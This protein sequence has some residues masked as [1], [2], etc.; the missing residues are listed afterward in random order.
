M[1]QEIDNLPSTTFF[2]RRFTRRRLAEIQDT[3]RSFPQ[4]SLRELGHTI[5]EHLNW[6]TAKGTHCIHACLN[7]LKEME[8]V[9]LIQLPLKKN[10][11]TKKR[12]QKAIIWTDRTKEDVRINCSLR[13]FKSI[14][15]IMV[16]T[17]EDVDIWNEY[18]DRYHYL[19]YRR[20]VGPHIRYYIVADGSHEMILGCLLFSSAV[21]SLPCRD[22]WIGWNDK[23]RL[24]HL[25]LV[26]N[27]NRF[28]IFP[29]VD[30]KCLASKVLSIASQQITDDWEK[31][32][33][34]RPVL[35]E[36]F[37]DPAKFKGTSYRAANWLPIGKTAGRRSLNES[38]N[39]DTSQ[40]D[41]YAFP[42]HSDFESILKNER[43]P[44]STT[45]VKS[46]KTYNLSS[47][48]PFIHLW[49][50]IISIV[51]NVSDEFDQKW[52]IRNRAINTQLLILFIFRLVFS[53][54]KQGYGITIIEL[55]DQCKTMN[56]A[57][58]Q[59]KP[60]ASSAFCIARKKLDENIFKILNSAII[61]TYEPTL[62][63]HRWKHHR[64]YAVDGTKINLPR[65]L[66][67]Y[68]YKTPSDGSHYPQGLCS[69]LYQLK[70]KIPYDFDITSHKD[71]RKHAL[72][73]LKVLSRNDIVV[74]D[75]GYFSYAMLYYHCKQHIHAVFRI[76]QNTYNIIQ[77]FIASDSTDQIVEI[78]PSADRK[79]DILSKDP[80]IEVKPLQL[81]MIKYAVAGTTYI[82]GTT[83]LD[84]NTYKTEEF[85]D[86]YHSRWGVEE[87]YKIS[88]LLI[89]VEDFHGQTERGIKQELFASFVLITLNR[90]FATEIE[91]G[92]TQNQSYFHKN[93]TPEKQV[94]TRIN[95][96]NCLITIA[97]N[98]ENLL[99]QQSDLVKKTINS[100]M[101]SISAC[102]Q[103]VRPNRKYKRLSM[104][105]PKKW[106]P[107]KEKKITQPSAS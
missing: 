20:P 15:L 50:N 91:E 74:Y 88:K 21:C 52:Q 92:L 23:D 64:L 25:K 71:E 99:V 45:K 47:D 38:Y 32:H 31:C 46:S 97:R 58:P 90:I 8:N 53:K 96:K 51:I 37:I 49:Q 44:P 77:E 103:K 81:R 36:T 78:K 69:C 95:F 62:T 24:Q 82:V 106:R 54:N 9:G 14:N 41:Y 65:Q 12:V 59:V 70:T 43:N 55:W 6:V 67:S 35:L 5:C 30:V 27:N 85:S 39:S 29:W 93:E 75:R 57:L 17:K 79:R 11:T 72:S 94:H 7:A 19:H 3:V 22:Q 101:D 28:L 100:V 68:G 104:K 33:G 98:L 63:E 1:N 10:T 48:D 60:V 2:G 4:L 84:H 87:L 13:S 89:D 66:R 16:E 18:V 42:L 26:I 56:I 105:P 76:Q 102:R 34:Y 40:K 80:E 107:S 86:L 73:H 61:N 83:L